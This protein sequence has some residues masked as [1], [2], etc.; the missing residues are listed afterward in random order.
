MQ[1]LE[2][3]KMSKLLDK[4]YDLDM[5][6]KKKNDMMLRSAK[7]DDLV[8]YAYNLIGFVHAGQVVYG[9]SWLW[10]MRLRCSLFDLKMDTDENQVF[11]S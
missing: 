2:E 10:E 7:H 8:S 11:L 9:G 3:I 6:K 4:W 5:I 1:C